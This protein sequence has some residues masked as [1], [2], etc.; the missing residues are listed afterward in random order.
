MNLITRKKHKLLNYQPA[1]TTTIAG[2]VYESVFVVWADGDKLTDE[3]GATH[4]TKHCHQ[5]TGVECYAK[6]VA[7]NNDEISADNFDITI[8]ITSNTQFIIINIINSIIISIIIIS[9]IIFIIT[10]LLPHIIPKILEYIIWLMS[11]LICSTKAQYYQA[12]KQK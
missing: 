9:I 1:D 11:S 12:K 10:C 6:N 7:Y 4:H 5:T 3:T 8:T 2:D